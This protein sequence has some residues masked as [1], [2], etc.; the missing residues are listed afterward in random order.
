M[1][2]KPIAKIFIAAL[3]SPAFALA[4]TSANPPQATATA[5]AV[6][7]PAKIAWINLEQAIL[8]CDE[9]KKEFSEI[10]KF[11]EKK[12]Q[13]IQLLQK[14]IQTLK[15]QMEVQGPKLADDARD[16][17]EDQISD[18]ETLLQRMQQDAQKDF[19]NR[20]ARAGNQIGRKII[21][22]IEKLSKE[23]GL[24]AVAFLNPQLYAW[25]DPGLVMT[26]EVIKAYNAAHPAAAPA[27]GLPPASPLPKK[28]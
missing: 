2:R 19:D 8:G 25:V 5:P 17:L 1:S 22:I 21:P 24:S 15:N 9:G 3:C 4:Q 6:I 16:D 11:A 7:G 12:S 18:K 26:E 20:K 28:P 14:E 10:Q 27:A 13:D 23:K